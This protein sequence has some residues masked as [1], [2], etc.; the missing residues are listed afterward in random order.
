MLSELQNKPNCNNVISDF[1]EKLTLEGSERS[2]ARNV[3]TSSNRKVT[4][5]CCYKYVT[6]GDLAVSFS[7]GGVTWHWYSFMKEQK[8]VEVGFLK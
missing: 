7:L 4:F 8:K 6:G 2:F 5:A 3:T 1:L